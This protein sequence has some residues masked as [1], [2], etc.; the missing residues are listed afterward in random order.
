MT[1]INPPA[2]PGLSVL[3]RMN[4]DTIGVVWDSGE[5]N[6]VKGLHLRIFPSGKR[7][8]YFLYTDMYGERRRPKIGEGLRLSEAR[9]LAAELSAKVCLKFDF[10]GERNAKR[11]E[12]TIGESYVRL[13]GDYYAQDRFIRSGRRK[14]VRSLYV[15]RIE[16]I[17]GNR[18]LSDVSSVEIRQWHNSMYATSVQ[19]N[20]AVEVLSKIYSFA[21]EHEWTPKN[22]CLIV[23]SFPERKRKRIPTMDEIKKILGTLWSY[24]DPSNTYMRRGAAIHILALFYTGARPKMLRD[25]RWEHLVTRDEFGTHFVLDGKMT[26]EFGEKEK[27]FIPNQIMN[28]LVKK[29]YWETKVFRNGSVRTMWDDIC[30]AHKIENL[31]IRDARKTFASIG[32]KIGISIDKIGSTLN[33]RSAQTTKIYAKE[34]DNSNAET[35]VSISSEL[36]KIRELL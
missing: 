9:K 17:F 30:N 14:E 32:L 25:L 26:A 11:N 29:Y 23:K 15:S 35:V 31:W 20:R 12:K 13:D 36:D 1:S 18:R 24:T 21:I 8:F 34:F 5:T 27:L 7:A 19:A 4:R 28:L 2:T 10:Q 22:P 16:K 3:E 33:H 6:S